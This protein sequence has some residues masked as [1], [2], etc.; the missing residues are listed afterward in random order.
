[1]GK[2]NMIAIYE[3]KGKALEYA[4]LALNLYDACPHG[5][6]YCYCPAVLHRPPASF[7][8]AGQPREGILAAVERDAK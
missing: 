8:V 3:P 7:F 2:E 1:M 5:C 4:P 6:T